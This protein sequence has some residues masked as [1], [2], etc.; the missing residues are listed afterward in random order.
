MSPAPSLEQ[1]QGFWVGHLLNF[2]SSTEIEESSNNGIVSR[3]P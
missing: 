3:G 1:L 2:D